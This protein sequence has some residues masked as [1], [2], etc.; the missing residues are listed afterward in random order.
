MSNA[1]HYLKFYNKWFVTMLLICFN[2]DTGQP[3]SPGN[4]TI[5]LQD[6]AEFW[7]GRVEIF[8][9]GSWNTICDD[10]W[11]ILDA[12]VVCRMLGY[13]NAAAAHSRAY[14]PHLSI[15]FIS[16]LNCTEWTDSIR[17]C[18]SQGEADYCYG[19]VFVACIPRKSVL[20]FKVI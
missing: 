20:Q 16:D 1:N 19:L 17:N 10:S 15:T 14:F 5:R 8:Y 12:R 7:E 9:D 11:D 2:S 4:S 13:N 6:G 18:R 3:P